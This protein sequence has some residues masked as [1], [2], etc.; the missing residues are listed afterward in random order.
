MLPCPAASR[1]RDAHGFTLIEL[2]VVV[3]LIGVLA[4]LAFP[5]FTVHQR[6]AGNSTAKADLHTVAQAVEVYIGDAPFTPST[7][8]P[9]QPVFGGGFSIGTTV[10]KDRLTQGLA[11]GGQITVNA[12]GDPTDYCLSAQ[13]RTGDTIYY[14]PAGQYS[15]NNGQPDT[16]CVKPKTANNA[17]DHTCEGST[18]N[19]GKT[20]ECNTRGN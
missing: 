16:G 20:Q 10:V 4:G 15:V 18:N 3:T 11:L 6:R 8:I 14:R 2:L 7:P 5:L 9:V 12:A 19:D 1:N 17:N 13:Y